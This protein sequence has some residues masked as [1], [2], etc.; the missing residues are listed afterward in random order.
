MWSPIDLVADDPAL[1]QAPSY[2]ALAQSALGRYIACRAGD[3][4][5]QTS[6]KA[7]ISSAGTRTKA[8]P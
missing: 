1:G 6:K 5:R 4:M 8:S 3:R 7:S 2:A